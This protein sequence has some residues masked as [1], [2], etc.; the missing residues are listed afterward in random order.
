[1]YEPVGDYY[2]QAD[3]CILF[4]PAVI[5]A[6]SPIPNNLAVMILPVNMIPQ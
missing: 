6:L 4:L 2:Y 1:M 3:M 5:I